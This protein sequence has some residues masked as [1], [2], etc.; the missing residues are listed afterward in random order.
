MMC[1]SVW[2]CPVCAAK[3]WAKRGDELTAG[4]ERWADQGGRVMM[5][6]LTMRHNASQPLGGLWD[7]ASDGWAA[8]RGGYRSVRRVWAEVDPAGWIRV[9]EVTWGR[10]GWHVHIHALVLLRPGTTSPQARKLAD[11]MHTG[12]ARRLQAL[13]LESVAG[14]G[15]F[16]WKLL[17]LEDGGK[18]A[19]E[20]LAKGYYP[21]SASGELTGSNRK[22]GRGGNLTTFGI[23]A[24]VVNGETE[25]HGRELAHVWYEWERTSLGRKAMT[26][27]D[28]LRDRL[29]LGAEPGD[30]DLADDPAPVRWGYML[31]AADWRWVCRAHPT[32]LRRLLAAVELATE[33]ERQAALD[34]LLDPHG[35]LYRPARL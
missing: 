27:S 2:C 33:H 9:V 8:A 30:Q 15:G 12:W 22:D 32:I 28:G 20:Y 24:A 11:A 5:V 29:G 4:L 26:W 1:G 14:S 19:G 31:C 17:R 18:A 34:A 21:T 16:H 13:G 23:L 7:S 3:V 6:T 10:N 35:I 25:R